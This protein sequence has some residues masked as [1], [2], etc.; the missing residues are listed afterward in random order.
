MRIDVQ[1][2]HVPQAYVEALA[3]RSDFPRYERAE[4]FWWA[5]ASPDE[6]LPMRPPALDISIKLAEMDAQEID[7]ALISINIPG[8]DLAKNPREADE[9][10]RIGNDALAEAAA[11]H[12]GRFRGVASVGFGDIDT[13]CR[14]VERCA[15]ELDFVGLQVFAYVGGRRYIDDPAHE[16]LWALLAARG[17][18]LVLHP[19]PSPSGPHYRD[20]WL[21]PM[22]GFMFDECLAALRLILGGVLERHPDLKVLLPHGGRVASSVHRAGGQPE[23]T[24]PRRADLHHQEPERILQALFYG[25]GRALPDGTRI[26]RP[27]DGRCA[28]DVRKRR[29]LGAVA[30]ARG[31]GREARD[32]AQGGGEHLERHGEGVL[33]ALGYSA[34][35]R[36]MRFTSYSS[37]TSPFWLRTR[38][39]VETTPRSGLLFEGR[40]PVVSTSTV[41][42]SPT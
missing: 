9:L 2:H 29:P 37:T 23:R 40:T 20:H 5:W 26:R 10:A 19:G 7:L 36:I 28:H 8:P 34:L 11:L 22:I 32:I 30:A 31:D 14:E 33:R 24:L 6:K 35:L 1:T 21:G 16:P 38:W 42:V 17:I 27:G 39:W 15:D 12:P 3:A 18:P 41:S 25:H 13:T 4:D